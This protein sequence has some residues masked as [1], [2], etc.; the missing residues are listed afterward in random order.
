MK[1]R[2]RTQQGKVEILILVNHPMETGLRKDK[3]TKEVIPAHF[4]QNVN[5]ELNG[6]VVA[7]AELGIGISEN[8]LIGFRLNEGKTG[9][10]LKVSWSDNRGESDSKETTV[11]L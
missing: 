7:S 1:V 11:D 10:K 2:T 8:P 3:K 9:D 5:V 4:I 6:Q